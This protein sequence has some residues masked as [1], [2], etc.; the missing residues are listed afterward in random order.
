MHEVKFQPNNPEESFDWSKHER[1]PQ[2]R[3]TNPEQVRELLT[4]IVEILKAHG[5]KVALVGTVVTLFDPSYAW[6][7]IKPNDA[8]LLVPAEAVDIIN[9]VLEPYLYRKMAP[10]KPG[11][12][13]PIYASDAWGTLVVKIGQEYYI[14]GDIYANLRIRIMRDVHPAQGISGRIKAL[15]TGLTPEGKILEP[16][17]TFNQ[18]ASEKAKH[19]P[20]GSELVP[21]VPLSK[22]NAK[23]LI[24]P[25]K[26]EAKLK[27]SLRKKI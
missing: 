5:V 22:E 21:M 26:D 14:L 17:I 25:S 7:D 6:L 4:P 8:D 11:E 18:Q 27:I 10:D 24:D 12:E 1:P 19:T 23:F 13:H 16:E 20:I 3:I 15:I 2:L 9:K